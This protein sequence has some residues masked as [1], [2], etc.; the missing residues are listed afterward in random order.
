MQNMSRERHTREEPKAVARH[1]EHDAAIRSCMGMY[2]Q[3]CSQ[4]SAG[5]RDCGVVALKRR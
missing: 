4:I 5:R 3:M 2:C 1:D